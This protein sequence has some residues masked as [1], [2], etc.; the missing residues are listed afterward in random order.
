MPSVTRRA[1]DGITLGVYGDTPWTEPGLIVTGS[2]AVGG[3]HCYLQGGTTGNPDTSEYLAANQFGF[4]A[5]DFPDDATI[6]GVE[7]TYSARGV[8]VV[9]YP[10]NFDRVR[11]VIGGTI[12]ATEK[13]ASEALDSD[14][15]DYVFGGSADT[16]SETLST[17]NVIDPLF[18]VVVSMER[19]DDAASPWPRAVVYAVY[20]TVHYTIPTGGMNYRILRS[21]R[22]Y[23]S[24]A[25]PWPTPRPDI[26]VVPGA[27]W[28]MIMR[29]DS[30][31][32]VGIKPALGYNGIMLTF[33]PPP[34]PEAAVSLMPYYSNMVI[35]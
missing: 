25:V 15:T 27:N 33:G 12:G 2:P 16:W 31:L 11:L 4:L 23:F 9:S 1:G 34:P 6:A 35:D 26:P 7:A 5:E 32:N 28:G 8:S 20:L 30:R 29:G 24:P 18:G 10:I 13:A 19:S 22:Q 17:A 3:A 21:R 14:P